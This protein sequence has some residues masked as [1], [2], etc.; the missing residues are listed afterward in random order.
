[1]LKV[2]TSVKTICRRVM[3]WLPNVS[4]VYDKAR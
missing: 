2:L 4:Q 3:G 1:L